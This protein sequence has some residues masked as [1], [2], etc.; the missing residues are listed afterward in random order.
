MSTSKPSFRIIRVRTTPDVEATKALFTAY[1]ASLG[2]DLAF[3]NF[4]GEMDAMPGQY[5]PPAGGELFLRRDGDDRAVGCVGLRALEEPCQGCCEMK[6]LFVSPAG[7]G[8]GVGK[9]LI[10]AVVDV[11]TGLGYGEIRLDTLPS[12]AQAV[13]LYAKAG[14]VPIAPYYESPLV[15]T[16]FMALSL[17][18]RAARSADS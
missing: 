7:R 1:A 16:N 4:A 10:D 8:L 9:A 3:Q 11:A 18:G 17:Q 12:M 5:A 15:R 2:F 13:S 6:R 14:F